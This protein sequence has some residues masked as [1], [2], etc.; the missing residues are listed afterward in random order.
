MYIFSFLLES[1]FSAFMK[2]RPE[3]V[4]KITKRLDM[5]I[6]RAVKNWRH[7]ARELNVAPEVIE[8]LKWY[9]TFSPTNNVF[10]SLEVAKPDLTIGK[11]KK[12]FTDIGRKDLKELLD[13]GIV[14]SLC[15]FFY[16]QAY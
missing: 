14:F 4:E 6:T 9:G 13:G 15:F 2:L 3:A 8:S 16:P 11:L 1:L 5:E 10:D 12:V 7:F